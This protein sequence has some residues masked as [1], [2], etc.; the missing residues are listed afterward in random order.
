MQSGKGE[1]LFLKIIY[2]F[3]DGAFMKDSK[4]NHLQQYYNNISRIY[5]AEGY[6]AVFYKCSI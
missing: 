3:L 1:S 5:R 4:I 6:F 2:S